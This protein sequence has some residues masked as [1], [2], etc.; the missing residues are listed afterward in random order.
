MPNQELTTKPLQECYG[1]IYCM[2]GKEE[3]V[4]VIISKLWPEVIATPAKIWKRRSN[5]GKKYYNIEIAIPGYIFFRAP[6]EYDFKD[7][8][9]DMYYFLK[10]EDGDWHLYGQDL[11]FTEWL[12]AH[13]G[14]IGLSKAYHDGERVRILDGPLKELEG[15]I[16]KIDKRS[17]NGQVKLQ[18]NGKNVY[19]WLGF[20]LM[21][22]AEDNPKTA[23]F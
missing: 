6:A 12:I 19:L 20:E 23:R 17:R 7:K 13:N 5:Q 22:T 9:N 4:S 18:I 11:L 8:P 2:S 21:E 15:Y 1:I 16:V 10:T 3:A 14:E